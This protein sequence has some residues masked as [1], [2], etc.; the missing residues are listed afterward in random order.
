MKFAWAILRY[1]II[2]YFFLYLLNVILTDYNYRF[3][4]YPFQ[5][6]IA[7]VSNVSFDAR[8]IA[9]LWV[10]ERIIPSGRQ[11]IGQ[12]LTNHKLAGYDEM[13]FLEIA[14]GRCSQDS[15]FIR[16]IDNL[17]RYA[18][19]SR[20]QNLTDVTLLDGKALL[21]FFADGTTKKITLSKLPYIEGLD[22]VIN[23]D[24]L[25]NS[26]TLGTD[27]YYITFNN[28]IDFPSWFLY[29]EGIRIPLIH[30]DFLSFAKGNLLDT[31]A[32]CNILECSRQNLAYLTKQD[33]LQPV[34]ENVKSNL[35]L[36]SDVLRQ[37]W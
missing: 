22:K 12:I 3:L 18:L 20:K 4:T 21:C 28:S 9:L 6:F 13:T 2:H 8:Q 32:S 37:R 33:Y 5:D 36:K 19:S 25:F 27:G 24:L 1:F 35:Y 11:N 23:N 26:C 17:P 31:T 10:R 34:K 30:S 29:K 16:K 15:I 7:A 14:D